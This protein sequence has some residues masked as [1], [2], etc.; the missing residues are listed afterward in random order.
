MSSW[1]RVNARRWRW[2]IAVAL[3]AIWLSAF[4]LV[5]AHALN[6]PYRCRYKQSEAKGNLKALYVAEESYKSEHGI[7]G[8]MEA[9]G[10]SPKGNPL[11]YRYSVDVHT[12]AGGIGF[13][14]IAMG[15]DVDGSATE[16][17]KQL[18]GDVIR[19]VLLSPP[20]GAPPSISGDTWRIDQ[21]NKIEN[22]KNACE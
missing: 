9:V 19:V 20:I 22:T 1:F 2:V 14:A 18:L 6:P 15:S 21:N 8:S 3:A 4:L 16:A 10:F 7:Y 17:A 11:R 5:P 13:T 12:G